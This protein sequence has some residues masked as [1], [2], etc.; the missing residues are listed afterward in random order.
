MQRKNSTVRLWTDLDHNLKFEKELI[1]IGPDVISVATAK[2]RIEVRLDQIKGAYVEEGL[3]IG[4]LVVK[5]NNGGELELAYFTKEL[6]PNFKRLA[7]S[8]EEY[9]KKK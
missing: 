2:K 1:E 8:L 7:L 3:G 6:M 5:T 9:K 4:K